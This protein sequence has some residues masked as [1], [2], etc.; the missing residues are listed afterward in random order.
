MEDLLS[1]YILFWKIFSKNNL[2]LVSELISRNFCHV[3]TNRETMIFLWNLPKETGAPENAYLE[4]LDN[5]VSVIAVL[6]NEN[7]CKII[8]SA[9]FAAQI[10][11]S[12]DGRRSKRETIWW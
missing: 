11:P 6:H 10:A 2:Q 9:E 8:D 5:I 7:I 4:I 12:A 1:T 3:F